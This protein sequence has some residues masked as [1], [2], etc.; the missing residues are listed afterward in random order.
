LP[1]GQNYFRTRELD[2]QKGA[3]SK[4][5]GGEKV[6]LSGGSGDP[7]AGLVDLAFKV[8]GARTGASPKRDERK[9]AWLLTPKTMYNPREG[10]AQG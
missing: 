3:A 7:M 10:W 2:A 5:K 9:K 4:K 8:P 1:N 6:R